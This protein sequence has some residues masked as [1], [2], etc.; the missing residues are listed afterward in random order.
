MGN[1]QIMRE[2]LGL[3][4]RTKG[5]MW[6][7][8]AN[9][10]LLNWSSAG[11]FGEIEVGGMFFA[12]VP[13]EHWPDD[14][15]TKKV[16][17]SAFCDDPAIGDR[18]QEIVFIGQVCL[19]VC[20]SID[21]SVCIYVCLLL[22]HEPLLLPSSLFIHAQDLNTKAI[23]DLLD[24]CLATKDELKIAEALDDPLTLVDL[25]LEP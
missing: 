13:E 3:I 15:E 10:L 18:R 24:S 11:A 17:R 9:D 6:L 5:F 12:A 8:T 20:R 4:L 22:Y 14:E 1:L 19:S 2:E 21:R 16:I 23:K 25:T 7:A